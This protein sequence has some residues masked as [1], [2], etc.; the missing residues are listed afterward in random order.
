MTRNNH[1]SLVMDGML[2]F[3]TM[4]QVL[5]TI[6]FMSTTG[7]YSAPHW[8]TLKKVLNITIIEPLIF[9]PMENGLRLNGR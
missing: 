5:L 4:C 1:L 2:P 6:M 8:L 9:Q 3:N 7:N